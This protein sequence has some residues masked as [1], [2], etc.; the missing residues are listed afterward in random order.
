MLLASSIAVN[1]YSQTISLDKTFGQNGRMII[2][3]ASEISFFDFDNHGNII[4]AGS[5]LNSGGY[6]DLTITKTNADGIIDKSFGNEGVSKVTDYDHSYPRGLKITND[7][8]IVVIGQFTK[9]MFHGYETLIMRFN[10]NG[11]VDENFGDNGKVNINFNSGD[12]FSLNCENN[13]FMLLGRREGETILINGNKYYTLKG[14]SISK[15]DYN[16]NIDGNFGDNGKAHLPNY[17]SPNSIKILKDGSIAIAGTYNQD[18]NTEL[19]FCKLTSVGELDK[20]FAN[21][22]VWH[23]N[24]MKDFDLDYESFS[25]I[26]EDNRGNLILSG[27]GITN[28]LGWRNRAFLSKFFYNGIIDT[29]FGENGFYSFD[30]SGNYNEIFNIGDKYVTVGWDK[31][32]KQNKIIYVNCDGSFSDYIYTCGLY[33]LRNMKLQGKLNKIILGGGYR[34][35]DASSSNFALERINFDFGVSIQSIEYNSDGAMIFPNPA[36]ESLYFDN[37]T[38]FEVIDIQGKILLKSETPVKSVNIGNLGA[39]IYFVRFGNRVKKFVKE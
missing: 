15:L 22:G 34:I 18:P 29:D 30:F 32:L 27:W 20:D 1:V 17:I 11:T 21:D 33:Y 9:I 36:K 10:E 24:I 19:G 6:Y 37:K 4:A 7:N 35:N 23:M 28:S 12:L 26:L 31:N 5:A 38:S 16:G 13:D 39:G 2:P 14:Y 8:K 25:N 3:S